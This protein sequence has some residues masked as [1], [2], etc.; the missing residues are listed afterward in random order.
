MVELN[1]RTLIT[2]GPIPI[3]LIHSSVFGKYIF[4]RNRVPLQIL[5]RVGEEHYKKEPSS[6]AVV[7]NSVIHTVWYI[8][9]ITLRKNFPKSNL[10]PMQHTNIYPYSVMLSL[11]IKSIIIVSDLDL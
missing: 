4:K 6:N 5:Y 8:H 1:S 2:V 11:K 10:V 3:D 9:S 7:E